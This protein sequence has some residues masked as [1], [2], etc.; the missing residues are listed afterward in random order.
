MEKLEAEKIPFIKSRKQ[1]EREKFF[2]NLGPELI[3]NQI[4]L[5]SELLKQQITICIALLTVSLIFDKIF[6]EKSS[7]KLFVMLAFFI[8]LLAAF[9]GLMPFDRQDV[10]MESPEDIEWF[11]RD[12]LRFKKICFCISG[13]MIIIGLFLIILKVGILSFA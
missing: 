13:C 7:I 8:G 3:K 12:A 1:T 11:H 10:C 6:D 9:I 5:A 4:P 2:L